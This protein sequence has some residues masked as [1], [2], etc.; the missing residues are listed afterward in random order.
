MS[1][2]K[3]GSCPGARRLRSSG[4]FMEESMLLCSL[5]SIGIETR[6]LFVFEIFTIEGHEYYDARCR[7]YES[8]VER[9]FRGAGYN[10]RH[11]P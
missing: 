9:E 2:H 3:A 6:I 11:E 8:G 1:V 5:S 7:Y 4:E 10:Q